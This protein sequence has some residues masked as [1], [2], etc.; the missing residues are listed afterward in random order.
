MVTEDGLRMLK[1]MEG[2]GYNT[3][4][5][6][7]SVSEMV[8]QYNAPGG[9]R[10]A[11]DPYNHRLGRTAPEGEDVVSLALPEGAR[12][13]RPLRD[14]IPVAEELNSYNMM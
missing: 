4:V 7:N 3:R 9:I 13:R 6:P 8:P 14:A 12:P 2:N 1:S 5:H 10:E 11:L